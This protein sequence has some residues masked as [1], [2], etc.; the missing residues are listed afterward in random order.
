MVAT[1]INNNGARWVWRLHRRLFIAFQ[2]AEMTDLEIV[3]ACA[4]AA[5]LAWT[6]EN[7]YVETVT[8]FRGHLE[9]HERYDPLT[10]DAQAMALVK[11]LRV[12]FSACEDA[13]GNPDGWIVFLDGLTIEDADLNRAICLA[14]AGM[15]K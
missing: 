7:G 1:C 5:G 15:K 12:S 6:A 4:E 2:G 3:K 14:V 9:N 8:L 13:A 10:N 11:K